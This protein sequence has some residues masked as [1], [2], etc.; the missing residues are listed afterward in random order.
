[1]SGQALRVLVAEDSLTVRRRLCETLAAEPGIE[2]VG[3]VADGR[4][5]IELCAALRPDIVT[6]DM[7]MPVMSGLAATE[8][9]MAHCPTPILIV[10]A[11]VNRGELFKTYDALAAGAVDVLEKPRGDET[12]DRWERHFI[13]T[14]RL[15][16][17]IKVITHLRARLR[18]PMLSLHGTP[19]ASVDGCESCQVIAV[20]ASTGGP[21]ALV[22]VLRGLAPRIRVPALVVLHINEPFGTAFADWLDAQVPRPVAFARHGES[23]VDLAG[24]IVLAP[25]DHH[26]IVRNGTTLLTRTPELHHCRPSVDALF[27]SIAS[28]CGAGAVG[29]L[30]TGMGRDGASG[31]LAMRRAG[32][33]TVAQDEASC[34]VYGMPREAAR[35]GAAERILPLNEIGAALG[36]LAEAK[37]ARP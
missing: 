27:E 9:I 36:E 34:V 3:E 22:E 24:R 15:V 21:G 1:M 2:V 26:L 30:L 28:A 33:S 12:D 23:L 17:R 4:R 32:A 19:A 18:Q 16:A 31:L 11:S 20:G 14:V 35:L 25:P 6:M 29:C 13:D 7:M 5:A 8:Y 10:S 37:E